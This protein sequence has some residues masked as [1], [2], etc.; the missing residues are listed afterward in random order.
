[1]DPSALDQE[2]RAAAAAAAER[3][4]LERRHAALT[5]ELGTA[6]L[7]LDELAARLAAESRDVAR[8]QH[9]VWGA[10]YGVFADR[11]ARLDKE[12]REAAEAAL[13][14]DEGL[15][16]RDR[17]AG[18]LAATRDRLRSLADAPARLERL[19]AAREHAVR[20]AGGPAAAALARFAEQLAALDADVKETDEAI[21]A[22]EQARDALDHLLRGLSSAREW[23]A[24]D[25]MTDSFLV[26]MIK[27][28]HLD[29]ARTHAGDAQAR[30][31]VFQRE[32]GD[33]GRALDGVI[34]LADHHRFLDT[35][36]DNLFS[37]LSVQSRIVES[38]A[39]VGRTHDAV[40]RQLRGLA[41][42]RH[43]LLERRAGVEE[44]RRAWLAGTG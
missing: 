4:R 8:Y 5:D 42:R 39:S 10:L 27:R 24:V 38:Q 25:V 17:L 11:G 7:A 43:A 29:D 12:R 16:R 21:A 13:R 14:H 41:E 20:T 31:L 44:T 35:F 26:S 30:L 34:E 33:V 32:L 23:G 6:Q 1:M 22:G 40:T 18:E 37:D 15:L 9:G 3:S 36:F 19:L 2:L 28:D